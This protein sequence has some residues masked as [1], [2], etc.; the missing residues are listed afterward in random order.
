MQSPWLVSGLFTEMLRCASCRNR[1]H[2]GIEHI[3]LG[4]AKS[5]KLTKYHTIDF[6]LAKLCTGCAAGIK[7]QLTTE[8]CQ[9]N[10]DTKLYI[11]HSVR[12]GCIIFSVNID[13]KKDSQ[14]KFRIVHEL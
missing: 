2:F 4:L 14:L 5:I 11:C 13:I 1:N 3:S 6:V 7:L 9:I 12:I 8:A 10:K